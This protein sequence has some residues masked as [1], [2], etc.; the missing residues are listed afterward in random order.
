MTI[1]HLTRLATLLLFTFCANVW[2]QGASDTAATSAATV[3][4]VADTTAPTDKQLATDVRH[5]LRAARK[6]GLKSTY[7][8]VRAHNGAVTLSG[9]VAS[10]DQIALATSV[11]RGVNGVRSVTSKIEIRANTGLNGNQ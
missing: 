11:A 10:D 5:A 3:A 7:I 8:R 6:Q 1:R 9:V 4:S 2:A